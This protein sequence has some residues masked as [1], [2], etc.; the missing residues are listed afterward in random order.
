MVIYSEVFSTPDAVYVVGLAKS[1]SSYTIHLT[2][3]SPSTGSLIESID[4]PSSIENGPSEIFILS[5]APSKSAP[6]K[7][8]ADQHQKAPH[9]VWLSQGLINS[10]ALSPTLSEKPTKIKGSVYKGIVNV[11]L[12]EHGHFVGIKEDGSGRVVKLTSKGALKV[13]WEFND[14]VSTF[15]FC[16]RGSLADADSRAPQ[17]TSDSYTSSIYSGGLDRDG[18]PYISR[19]FWSHLLK[20][21]YSRNSCQS[22]F[23]LISFTMCRKRRRM[24]SLL[25]LR[26][27]RASL[28][29]SPSH[30]QR[31]LTV[32][33]HMSVSLTHSHLPT[34]TST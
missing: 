27:E 3:L 18:L 9:L 31:P 33:S 21:P 24:F 13:I 1:L 23:Q 34:L 10:V 14:S 20:V 12:G 19:V 29:A 22:C 30:S 26:K 16:Y 15:L 2:S 32:S 6:E 7:T 4:I 17:A 8:Q 11:G 25:T 5:P 28:Q